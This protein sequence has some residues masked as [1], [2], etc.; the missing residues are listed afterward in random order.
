MRPGAEGC[1]AKSLTYL[2]D[3][4]VGRRRPCLPAVGCQRNLPSVWTGPQPP[5]ES[6]VKA[7]SRSAF[8][9]LELV[10]GQR[11]MV[12]RAGGAVVLGNSTWGWPGGT[13]ALRK[14]WRVLHDKQEAHRSFQCLRLTT[15]MPPRFSAVPYL[16]LRFRHGFARF[17][18]DSEFS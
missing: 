2:R 18:V 4:R 11:F 17:T 16:T 5:E 7:D 9:V 13:P 10:K 15:T 8:G 12:V 1:G 6:Q 14:R 3:Q